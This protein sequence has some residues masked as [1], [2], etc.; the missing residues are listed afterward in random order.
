MPAERSGGNQERR[1][2]RTPLI[3]RAGKCPRG[4]TVHLHVQLTEYT[5]W[6]T[7]ASISQ[8]Q[9]TKMRVTGSRTGMSPYMG[10][11]A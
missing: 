5:G 3:L 6:G 2:E 4:Q 1:P 10:S 7:E 11:L 9:S 8:G